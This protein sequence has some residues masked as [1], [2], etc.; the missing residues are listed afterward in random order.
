MSGKREQG[1]QRDDLHIE[2]QVGAAAGG[3]EEAVASIER[4]EGG[5]ARGAESRAAAAAPVDEKGEV[6]A[7]KKMSQS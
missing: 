4:V 7:E 6:A 1:K 3:V 2:V 5:V